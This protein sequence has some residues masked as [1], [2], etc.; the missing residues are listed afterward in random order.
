MRYLRLF[1]FICGFLVFSAV[2]DDSVSSKVRVYRAEHESAILH[3]FTDLL[4]IP[5]LASDRPNIRKNA[6][7]IAEMLRRRGV[8]PRLLEIEGAPP[9]VYG[10]LRTAGAARTVGIY[11]HYDG[12]HVDR[13]QWKTDPWKPVVSGGYIYARS[14]GDDKAPIIAWLAALDALRSSGIPPTVNLVF[15][16]EGEEEAGSPHLRAFFEKYRGLLKADAW[17][18]CDGP[19]HQ[20]RRMQLYFGAR[21][22]TEVEMTVYGPIRS[23]H[24]GHYGNWAPNPAALL[25]NLLASMRDTDGRVRVAGFADDVRPLNATEQRALAEVPQTDAP[26]RDELGLA[27]TEGSGATLA[28]LITRPALNIRGIQSGHVAETAQNAIPTDARASIDFRLVPNQSPAR[29]QAAVE[30]HIREQGFY[31]VRDEPDMEVRRAHPRIIRMQWGSGYP[32]ARTS[33]EDPASR[34][35]IGVLEKAIGQPIV[36]MPTLG[37]SVPMYLFLNLLKAPAIGLPIANHDD[38]QHAANENLRLQN[39]WDGIEA[40]GALLAGL[41]PAWK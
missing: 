10:G 41:G 27:W 22:V 25:A 24:S 8:E 26:L 33:M 40:F 6:D 28:E 39:L 38:N 35:V 20:T 31:I 5:N 12:Q 19:V 9:V 15:F 11:A 30:A 36:K 13:S 7:A 2:A 34:A 21:G 14:A 17:F 1:A 18:L 4:S 37:G 32:A 23:L 29:V 3:E 16:F